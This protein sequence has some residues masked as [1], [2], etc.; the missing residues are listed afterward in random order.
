[1]VYRLADSV[2]VRKESWGLLFYSQ[3]QHRALFIKSADWLYPH[4]FDGN[5]TFNR[6]I[7]DIVERTRVSIGIIEDSIQN[8]ITDLVKRGVVIHE[9]R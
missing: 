9:L 2:Q 4:Y 5:W 7:A 3:T 1:V 8:S 6:I